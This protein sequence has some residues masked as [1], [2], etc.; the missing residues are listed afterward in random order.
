MVLARLARWL[1][2]N[3]G[4]HVATESAS[5]DSHQPSGAPLRQFVGPAKPMQ[6]YDALVEQQAHR[7]AELVN[8]SLAL[9]AD[10]IDPETRLSRLDFAEGRLNEVV[11]LAERHP[12][13]KIEREDEVRADI[14]RLREVYSARALF[15]TDELLR[16]EG[17]LAEVNGQPTHTLARKKDDL[18][19]MKACMRA[20]VENYWR[21]PQG[22][23]LCA[24]PFF[25]ERVAVLQR[26][27]K[28]YEAEI[29]A[30][31]EW[32]KIVGDYEKQVSAT[33]VGAKVWA[34]ARSNKIIERL[35]RARHLLEGQRTEA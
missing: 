28:N 4:K 2:K 25:F 30:C 34:G 5:E 29:A 17:A 26:K 13:I 20:E 21:Q 1:S 16:G 10:S 24:A 14:E 7:L 18:E 12:Q 6:T 3:K 8:E 31:E 11:E 33:G 32:L 9:A 35:P 15:T 23:R 19:V 27:A 22:N